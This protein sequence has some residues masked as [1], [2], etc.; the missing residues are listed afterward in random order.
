MSTKDKK[1][2]NGAPASQPAANGET[3]K[4]A[5]RTRLK[6]LFHAWEAASKARD[7]AEAKL[8]ETKAA[9]SE[10]VKAIFECAG[11][12]GPFGYKG[13]ELIVTTRGPTEK[14]PN[15][16]TTYFFRGKRKEREVTA[17]G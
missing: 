6:D 11:H 4:P 5:D 16:K 7:A 2:G 15:A 14:H 17:I 1:N 10:S 9:E 13:D 8:E 3:A 12:T